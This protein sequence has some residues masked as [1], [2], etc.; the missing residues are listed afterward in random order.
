[1]TCTFVAHVEVASPGA[2]L[3][4]IVV[5][6]TKGIIVGGVDGGGGGGIDRIGILGGIGFDEINSLLVVSSAS[7]MPGFHANP[8]CGGGSPGGPIWARGRITDGAKGGGGKV[9]GSIV[10]VMAMCCGGAHKGTTG[11][12]K[13]GGGDREGR[14]TGGLSDAKHSRG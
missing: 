10:G 13:G 9:T 6:G 11:G 7:T 14:D 3:G 8:S 1:M 12:A 2:H 5:E 4:A